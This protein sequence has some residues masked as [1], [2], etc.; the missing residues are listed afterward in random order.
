M[1]GRRQDPPP[2]YLM[3]R[4]RSILSSI[5]PSRDT[6]VVHISF[7][8]KRERGGSSTSTKAVGATTTVST[9]ASCSKINPSICCVTYSNT[10]ND[11]LTRGANTMDTCIFDP[12]PPPLL[13]RQSY[14]LNL[15]VFERSLIHRELHKKGKKY[16]W[17][18]TG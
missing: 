18:D 17:F 12:P 4:G 11:T 1:A 2:I 14:I 6:E 15:L 16:R 8:G 13:L 3:D 10:R 9:N 5:S 7:M